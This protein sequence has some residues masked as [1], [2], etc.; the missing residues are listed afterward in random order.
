MLFE[1]I[2]FGSITFYVLSAIAIVVMLS[3]TD[4][5]EDS[6]AI[7]AFVISVAVFW[8]L[9]KPPEISLGWI[10]AYFAVGCCWWFFVFNLRLIKLKRFLKENPT[11]I[12]DGKVCIPDSYSLT[13]M[14]IDR[15]RVEE[16]K[17][18]DKNEPSFSKFFSRT[19]CWPLNMLKFF[20]SDVA[21]GVWCIVK[22]YTLMYK[23]SL[24]GLR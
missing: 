18:I 8:G 22:R 24:L 1:L 16:M 20:L 21:E 19:F 13:G 3:F 5:D 14:T 23:Q 2:V 17:N 7:V 12:E 4:S 11:F 9:S 15:K 10:A 6:V